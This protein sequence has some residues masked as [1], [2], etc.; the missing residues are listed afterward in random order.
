MN[1]TSP[2]SNHAKNTP[3]K[4]AIQTINERLSYL[5]W[6]ELVDKTANWFL[7][8]HGT[9]K[10]IGIYM[11]NGLPFLQLFTGASAAGCVAVPFDIKWKG[12]ELQKRVHLSSPTMLI[13]TEE[14]YQKLHPI[15]PIVMLWE[16]CLKEINEINF[17]QR[18]KIE[19]DLPF[20]MGFTSGSTGDPKAFIRSHTS[21]VES[22]QCNLADLH[23]YKNDHVLIPGALI[24]SHFLYG[25]ISTLFLGGTVYVLEKFSSSQTLS[26]IHTY[27]ISV[28][29]LVPTMVEALLKLDDTIEKHVKIISSGAKWEENSKQRIP[30]TF[31]SLSMYELF[32]ASE[33][34]FITVLSDQQHKLK[35]GSVGKP[36]LNV[37]IQIRHSNKKIASP[38]EVGKIYVRSNMKF[39][40]YLS[41]DHRTIDS[42]EDENGWITVHDMGYLDEEG[43]LY[44][45]GRE[46]NMILY[47]GI[48]IFPEEI[49]AVLS[50]HPKVEM[51]AVVGVTDSYWGQIV[52]AVVK[53]CA[54]KNELRSLCKLKLA[55]YKIPRKW[56]F[57]EE[58][59]LTTSGKIARAQVREMIERE[60]ISL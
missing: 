12:T 51:V 40:G 22:F 43:Y 1:I 19:G 15:Y 38:N 47:G 7:S 35:P 60:G 20:Y 10:T 25:A 18:V 37:D 30:K 49:E 58:M 56:F 5:E 32:G 28:I 41:A 57:I 17:R 16:D 46:N 21:W 14:L 13:T 26:F 39:I 29:Y 4:L 11:P 2:Y 53:G 31:P 55:S 34:S 59:P 9:N 8:L 42:I 54:T 24:H 3:D 23:M 27:P 44:I 45:S 50:S 52:T 6:H 36:C 48:N 33:L